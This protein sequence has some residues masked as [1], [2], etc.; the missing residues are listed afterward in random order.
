MSQHDGG[1]LNLGRGRGP[2]RKA[3]ACVALQLG[4]LSVIGAAAMLLLATVGT[5]NG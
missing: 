4:E 3:L 1:T 5:F 2:S